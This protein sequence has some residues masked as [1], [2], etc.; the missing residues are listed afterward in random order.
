MNFDRFTKE[1]WKWLATHRCKAH[2]VLYI[3]HR[4]CFRKEMPD[5]DT[6]TSLKEKVGVFDIETTGIK[7]NW[8][9]ML[10]WCIKDLEGEIYHD[11]ATRKEVRDK[12]DRRIVKSAIDK[13]KEYDRI[14]TWY[15][16][17]FDIKYLRSRA[18]WYGFDFPTYREL[19]HTD[20]Y[21]IARNRL[22][23]HSNRLEA[24]CQFLEIP[25]KNHPMTPQLWKRAGAGEEEALKIVLTHCQE[26][27]I[28][29]EE[30]WNRLKDY[31]AEL[32][33]SI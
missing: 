15:G 30:V 27:V 25:A 31:A 2:G 23:L 13:L 20:V 17:R 24:V 29:T 21:Y 33:R 12:N 10:V 28:S 14:L 5:M 8:S 26:D 11:V 32:K 4:N 18:L 7:A 9:H 19:L 16:T 22:A 6:P 1:D 3:D